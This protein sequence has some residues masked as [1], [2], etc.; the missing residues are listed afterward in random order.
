[1]TDSGVSWSIAIYVGVGLGAFLAGLGIFVLCSRAGGLLARLHRTLD[2]VDQQV[3][4]LAG[5]VATTLTH[6]GGI[7]DTADSTIARLG[8]LVGQVE[9]VVAGATKTAGVVGMAASA[10]AAARAK[11]RGAEPAEPEASP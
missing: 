10:F 4:T 6:V 8:A 3:T 11:A 7:A 2:V 1:M 5:P 9:N